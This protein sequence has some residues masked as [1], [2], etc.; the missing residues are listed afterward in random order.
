MPLYYYDDNGYKIGPINKKELYVLAEKGAIS[1]ETR[2]TDDKIE[3]KA[4]NIPKL[5]FGDPEIVRKEI[6]FDP[7]NINFEIPMEIP[8]KSIE[9]KPYQ[10]E[11]HSKETTVALQTSTITPPI[12]SNNLLANTAYILV[13]AA[14][15]CIILT[16]VNVVSCMHHVKKDLENFNNRK[17]PQVQV[18]QQIQDKMA[19]LQDKF[20]DK[21]AKPLQKMNEVMQQNIPAKQAVTQRVPNDPL[22][23]GP[24]LRQFK[25]PPRIEFNPTNANKK[26][27][28]SK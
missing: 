24:P 14:S 20:D 13:S 4:K 21:V 2:L 18:P 17:M 15:L 6:L 12:K 23:L 28:Q 27:P 5:K 25:P 22:P 11:S 7:Q 16:F 10:N 1:P 19:D 26:P 3:V 8:Q 9:T